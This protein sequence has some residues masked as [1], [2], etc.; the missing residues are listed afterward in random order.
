M[1]DETTPYSPDDRLAIFESA[2]E[3]IARDDEESW[4]EPPKY[5]DLPV[6]K[7]L[8]VALEREEL[9]PDLAEE[10]LAV[11]TSEE[12]VDSWDI[13]E[14]KQFLDCISNEA[15]TVIGKH[16]NLNH[17]STALLLE[18]LKKAWGKLY[19]LIKEKP[20]RDEEIVFLQNF[21]M[22]VFENFQIETRLFSEKYPHRL[23]AYKKAERDLE[24]ALDSLSQ[25]I[26]TTRREAN[27][28]KREIKFIYI[29]TPIRGTSREEI[30]VNE[31]ALEKAVEMIQ[32]LSQ[33][34][35]GDMIV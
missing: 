3:E 15:E 17:S 30:M 28:I 6:S 23:P 5:L 29:Y 8:H 10:L 16:K 34:P 12:T 19:K 1:S 7:K 14:A 35:D 25:Y 21:L 26:S 18:T 11:L 27:E 20:K 33:L 13:G 2:I 22:E 4:N 31:R 9:T 32:D 24:N